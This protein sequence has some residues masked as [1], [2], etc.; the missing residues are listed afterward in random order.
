M[1]V[2][3]TVIMHSLTGGGGAGFDND[4]TCL[5]NFHDLVF[6]AATTKFEMYIF[7]KTN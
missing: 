6:Q 2:G 5:I 4:W 3:Q 1:Y 7:Y